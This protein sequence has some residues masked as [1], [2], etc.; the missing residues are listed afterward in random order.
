[1]VWK[2]EPGPGL[3][4]AALLFLGCVCV[5][6]WGGRR[7]LAFP[8]IQTAKMAG[9]IEY[10]VRGGHEAADEESAVRPNSAVSVFF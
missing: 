10:K 4:P 3:S 6:E 7:W 9:N 8:R 5:G 1:M 2:K